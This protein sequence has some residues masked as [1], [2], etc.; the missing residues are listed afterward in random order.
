MYLGVGAEGMQIRNRLRLVPEDELIW[1]QMQQRVT[2]LAKRN[3][4]E[5]WIWLN[6][7][8]QEF[9]KG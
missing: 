8:D 3:V 7:F 2:T 9:G 6:C 5:G 4:D 1:C